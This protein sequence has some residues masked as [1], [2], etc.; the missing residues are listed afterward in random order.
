[1]EYVALVYQIVGF[2]VSIAGIATTG[3]LGVDADRGGYIVAAGLGLH[4]LVLF[5]L[6][7]VFST[8][9][10]KAAFTYREFGHATLNPTRGYVALSRTFGMFLA[11]LLISLVCLIMRGLYRTVGF[12]AGFDGGSKNEGLFALFDGLM[13][14][15]TVLGLAVFHPALVFSDINK[16]DLECSTKEVSPEICDR[17]EGV[18]HSIV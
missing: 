14:S 15:Q 17:G 16:T 3:G 6:L 1:M 10:I 2:G 9:L 7:V 12:A 4:V 13:V 5:F 18:N 8:G 11:V